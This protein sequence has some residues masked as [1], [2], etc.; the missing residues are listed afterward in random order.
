MLSCNLSDDHA[1]QKTTSCAQENDD[2]RGRCLSER[3]LQHAFAGS[4]L[5][6]KNEASHGDHLIH[7]ACG[8]AELVALSAETPPK[9]VLKK[10]RMATSARTVS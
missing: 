6:R 5:R 10:V 7:L 3:C 1:D 2:H 4:T 8:G 9:E